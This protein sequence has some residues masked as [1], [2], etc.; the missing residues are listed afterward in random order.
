[1]LALG[2]GLTGDI[3]IPG[4]TFND[5]RPL[6]IGVWVLEDGPW[7]IP[8]VMRRAGVW[9]D[10]E[11]ESEEVVLRR[12]VGLVSVFGVMGR[13]VSEGL[14]RPPLVVEGL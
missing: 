3:G 1:M 7:D 2:D 8:R 11:R 5:N 9:K 12:G 10:V 6:L 14:R 4:L 13:S